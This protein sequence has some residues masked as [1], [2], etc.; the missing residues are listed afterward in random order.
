MFVLCK[1]IPTSLIFISDDR[2]YQSEQLKQM[3]NTLAYF[4][5]ASVSKMI[6][7]RHLTFMQ[8]KLVLDKDTFL[9]LSQIKLRCGSIWKPTFWI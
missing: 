5:E 7:L 3:A 1:F 9:K 2:D 6:K 4:V 8:N